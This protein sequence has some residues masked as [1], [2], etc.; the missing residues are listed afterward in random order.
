DKKPLIVL[1]SANKNV[2]L[3]ARN[4]P[5]IDVITTSELNTYN[6]LNAKSLVLTEGSVTALEQFFNV[7]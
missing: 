7:E 3:S 4:L 6:V 5:S 1:S 2:Y